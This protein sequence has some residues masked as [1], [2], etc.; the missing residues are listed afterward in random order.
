MSDVSVKQTTTTP[1]VQVPLA[2]TGLL[3]KV[4]KALQKRGKVHDF[5]YRL[6]KERKAGAAAFIVFLLLLLMAIFAPLI[7]P[8]GPNDINPIDRLQGPSAQYWFGTDHLGRDLFSR[9]VH[10]AQTSMIIAFAATALATVISAA[11]GIVSGYIGGRT[12][13]ITQRFVDGWMT[14]PGLVVLIAFLAVFEASPLTI[15]IILAFLIGIGGSRIVRG[16]VLSAKENVYVQAAQSIG[17]STFRILWFHI[18]PNVTAPLI[19]LF[20]TNIGQVILIEST[21]AFLGLG[22]PPP[23]PAWGAMLSGDGRT[24]MFQNMWLAIFPGVAI[25]LAVFSINIFGD[26]LRDL[27]DPRMRGGGG[28]F[29]SVVRRPKKSGN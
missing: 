16:A 10:G 7:A 2:T 9:I 25:T 24:Y 19:I 15:I 4:P 5:F 28:R 27:L 14:M 29:M 18:L 22:V 17:A 11:I 12:D 21:L 13:M 20:T 23:T 26:A 8:Y 6:F 1:G 3:P